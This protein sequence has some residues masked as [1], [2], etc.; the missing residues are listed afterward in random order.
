M[1]A[2]FASFENAFIEICLQ[3]LPD[4]KQA[5]T[6]FD[7]QGWNRY[8]GVDEGEFEYYKNGTSVFLYAGHSLDTGLRLGCTIMDENVSLI[9]V[10][11][12]LEFALER[13][14]E[15]RWQEGNSEWGIVWSSLVDA[16]TVVFTIQEDLSGNGGAV[17]FE[18]SR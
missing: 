6:D 8:I 10:E 14:F 2:D 13:Y 11:T 9:E 4:M 15:G 3:A 7:N 1:Q 17:S 16:G 5:I 12:S 18:I